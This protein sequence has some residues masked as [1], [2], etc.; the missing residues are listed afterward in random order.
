[1][2]DNNNAVVTFVRRLYRANLRT[3]WFIAVITQ[4]NYRFF[5]GSGVSLTFDI[6][7]SDPMIIPPAIAVKS[8]V[9]LCPAS[10]Q[11]GG[12][13]GPAAVEVNNHPPFDPG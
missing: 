10:I 8:N 2:I 13:I 1:M 11:A 3:G 12:T 5:G 6:D 7:F 9:I 4:H